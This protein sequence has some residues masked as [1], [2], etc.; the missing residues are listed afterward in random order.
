M[1][2]FHNLI[3]K[4]GEP[5]ILAGY[6]DRGQSLIYAAKKTAQVVGEVVVVAAEFI[7]SIPVHGDAQPFD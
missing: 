1:Q 4:I 7:D 3:L 2:F 5:I 6:S